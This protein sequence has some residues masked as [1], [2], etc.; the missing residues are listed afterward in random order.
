MY[1]LQR[2]ITPGD[3]LEVFCI[4]LDQYLK[5]FL[6]MNTGKQQHLC[7]FLPLT[8]LQYLVELIFSVRESMIN[9][10][11]ENSPSLSD[12]GTAIN[13]PVSVQRGPPSKMDYCAA[14]PLSSSPQPLITSSD[15]LRPS[16]LPPFNADYPA[17]PEGPPV[18]IG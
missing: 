2:L 12:N 7:L 15:R 5:L 8:L 17:S 13:V 9:F 14:R 10:C 18:P 16:H 3:R 6:K 1:L 11:T 4:L